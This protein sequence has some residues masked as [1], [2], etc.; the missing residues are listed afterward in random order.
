MPKERLRLNELDQ[1]KSLT[2]EEYKSQIKQY[3]LELLSMQLELHEKKI[4]VVFV[5]E[6]PDAAGKGGAIKRLVERLDPRLIR[7][8][9]INKPT[10]E[11]FERHYMW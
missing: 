3:Q 9:S 11:E 2:Q 5:L 7:V 10:S 6:G 1:S 4:P 8:Y